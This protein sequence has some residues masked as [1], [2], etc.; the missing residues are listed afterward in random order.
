MMTDPTRLLLGDDASERALLESLR[1]DAPSDEL[2]AG[3]WKAIAA[4]AI[5]SGV[6]SSATA[7]VA[8][9]KVGVAGK[10]AATFATK[11]AMAKVAV[12]VAVCAVGA[13]AAYLHRPA[14]EPVPVI[15]APALEENAERAAARLLEDVCPAGV[16]QAP[17]TGLVTG[18][19]MTADAVE[20]AAPEPKRVERARRRRAQIEAAPAAK[21]VR[22][23]TPAPLDTLQAESRMLAQARARLRAG[24]LAG[25][26]QA[27]NDARDQ[28]A[29]GGSLGQ[30]RE[31]LQIELLAK[32]G[33]HDGADH[34]ARRFLRKHPDSPHAKT[35]QRFLIAP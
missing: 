21:V 25:A 30:E 31:V 11:A 23:S 17:C 29:Q 26:E 32:L 8:P 27:L 3:M 10:L 7:S 19:V 2:S 16:E 20:V 34:R 33:D 4:Q 24:D 15:A 14:E 9:V 18:S 28:F 5:A 35:V 13:G 6:A 22:A 1:S 12:V